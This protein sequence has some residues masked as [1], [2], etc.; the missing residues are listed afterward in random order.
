[1]KKRLRNLCLLMVLAGCVF[2]VAGL[3]VFLGREPSFDGK[4][5]SDWIWTMNAKPAG[6]EKE[7]ARAVVRKLGSN[8]VP[9]LLNWLRQEDH[10]SLIGR[11]DEVRQRVFFWLVGHKI[12]ANRSITSLRDFN[13]SRRA[14]AIWALPELD[15]TARR[16][17]IPSLIKMLYTC[18]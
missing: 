11:F 6:P 18:A 4:R 8:S 2:A 13:P 7:Q 9:L 3:S 5:F 15:P 14:M 1:M 12:I 16:S 10:P 17:A